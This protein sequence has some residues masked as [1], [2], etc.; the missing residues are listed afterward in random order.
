MPYIFSLCLDSIAFLSFYRFP[1]QIWITNYV[2]QLSLSLAV[3]VRAMASF[4]IAK[5]PMFKFK[6]IFPPTVMQKTAL[7]GGGVI[8]KGNTVLNSV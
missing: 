5:I 7:L 3:S 6:F 4:A 1:P 2:S 8:R